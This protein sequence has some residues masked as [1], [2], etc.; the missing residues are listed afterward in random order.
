[1]KFMNE[2]ADVIVQLPAELRVVCEEP[3]LNHQPFSEG[4]ETEKAPAQNKGRG[5][6]EKLY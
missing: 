4:D 5:K 1:M 6:R 3:M 2:N